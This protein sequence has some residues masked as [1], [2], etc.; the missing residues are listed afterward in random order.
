MGCS[1]HAHAM[2]HVHDQRMNPRR[3]LAGAKSKTS[4][5]HPMLH[6]HPLFLTLYYS[7]LIH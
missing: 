5:L 4:L 3:R 7:V 6:P 1:P 2:P